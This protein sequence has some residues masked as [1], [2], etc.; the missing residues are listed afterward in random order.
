[1]SHKARPG[2]C[3]GRSAPCQREK[4]DNEERLASSSR[5]LTASRSHFRFSLMAPAR[6][7]WL[8][9]ATTCAVAGGGI[10]FVHDA[11]VKERAALHAGVLRDAELLT[12][13]RA[14]RE[15]AGGPP[16]PWPPPPPPP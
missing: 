11:Q 5:R 8:A 3:A 16:Q 9:L 14:E 1:M 13:K 2:V 6:R 12:A 4:G 10:W 15:R 7:A